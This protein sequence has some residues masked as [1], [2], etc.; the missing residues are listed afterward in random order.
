MK[1]RKI[2]LTES[3]LSF[4]RLLNENSEVESIF[5]QYDEISK[6]VDQLWLKLEH[7]QI[8]D[9]D[10]QKPEIERLRDV[11]EMYEDKI[12][13]ISDSH[14]TVLANVEASLGYDEM[15]NIDSRLDN[16]NSNVSNKVSALQLTI[17]KL[18]DVVESYESAKSL[19]K[20]LKKLEI[21]N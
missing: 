6:G 5:R 4:I 3:Q 18:L 10:Q 15:L 2:V 13:N 9:I 12:L 7:F 11:A 21:N 8:G 19:F 20:N 14:E 17:L 1:N 16:K